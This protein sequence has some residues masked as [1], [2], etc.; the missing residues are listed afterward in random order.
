MFWLVVLLPGRRNLL[1]PLRRL[2]VFIKN[3]KLLFL[4]ART[5][6]RGE[7]GKKQSFVPRHLCRNNN[8]PAQVPGNK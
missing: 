5:R 3:F 2:E 1:A 4:A 8:P 7:V 6:V